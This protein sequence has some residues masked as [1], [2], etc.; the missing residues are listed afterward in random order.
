MIR[1]VDSLPIRV[2]TEKVKSR[3]IWV[4]GNHKASHRSL[5]LATDNVPGGAS[6]MMTRI[7]R[8]VANDTRTINEFRSS[9]HRRDASI[10]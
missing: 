3:L 6:K 9:L 5:E 1:I 8:R 4:V 2:A 10:I 7:D